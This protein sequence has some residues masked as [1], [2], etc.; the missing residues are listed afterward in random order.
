MPGANHIL[1]VPGFFGFATLGEFAYFAHVRDYLAEI[2]PARGVE[3]EVEVVHTNPTAS[4]DRRAAL[5]AETAAKL[6]E[7]SPGRLCLVGHSSGG[8]DA[9]LLLT[10]EARLPTQVD[11]ERIARAVRAVVD[12]FFADVAAERWDAAAARLDLQRFEPFFRQELRNARSEV[13]MPEPSPE[14]LMARDSTMPRAVAE[15]EVARMKASRTGM[16]FGDSSH[17]FAGITSQHALLALSLADAAA[18][19]LAARDQRT[20][21]R[22]SA[23]RQGC[24][25]GN[26]PEA[27][28]PA[29]HT[30]LGVLLTDD[31]TAYVIHSDDRFREAPGS[32]M[33]TTRLLIVHGA[34]ATWR[35]APQRDLLNPANYAV[36]GVL[37]SHAKN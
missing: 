16:P 12:S 24:P 32:L 29:T 14:E 1:L 31:S 35:I 18:R 22:E 15:W 20:Q 2:L 33:P 36:V 28:P 23:R 4:L 6:L 25:L 9:R 3:G 37:C 5:L 10:P 7:R 30:V 11:V 21:L 17:E 19:W 13:R 26:I 27:S 34:G 8:L